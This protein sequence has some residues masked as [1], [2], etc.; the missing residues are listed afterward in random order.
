MSITVPSTPS[1]CCLSSCDE[2]YSLILPLYP[3]T[4]HST[5][6]YCP[7][8]L[9]TALYPPY[10]VLYPLML[11]STFSHCSHISHAVLGPLGCS[12]FALCTLHPSL[13]L[14][15]PLPAHYSATFSSR[16]P[17]LSP[18]ALLPSLPPSLPPSLL[19]TLHVRCK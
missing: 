12:Y 19:S 14:L 3:F 2:L 15:P 6:S 11:P 5:P 7:P 1:Y 16:L 4:L 10:T 13:L 9:L 18:S 17:S 8:P